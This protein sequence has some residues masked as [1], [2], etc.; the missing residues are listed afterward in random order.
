MSKD[1]PS[2]INNGERLKRGLWPR[3]RFTG[4]TLRM[5]GGLLTVAARQQLKGFL[6][7]SWILHI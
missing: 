6:V 1:S 7:F 2:F 3:R 5:C 4:M